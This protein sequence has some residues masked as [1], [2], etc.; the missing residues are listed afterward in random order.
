MEINVHIHNHG[1][2]QMQRVLQLLE[3]IYRQERQMA[4]N[5]DQVLQDVNDETT[6]IDG[7]GTFIQGLKDQLAAQGID[8]AKLDAAFAG[9]EANKAKL[10]AALS[11]NTPAAGTT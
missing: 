11:A 7:I 3:A 5:I 9:A 6:L 8:Q 4:A 2:P 1:D 10:A